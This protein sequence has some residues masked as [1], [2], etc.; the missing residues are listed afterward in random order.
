MIDPPIPFFL[1]EVGEDEIREVV[2]TLR[3]GWL[4][5]GPRTRQ[6][7]QDF[8]ELVGARHA[9]AVN[10]AT[11]ALHLALDA[12]GIQPGD[13]VL[14]PTMTFAA[15]AEVVIYLGAKPVLVDC[16]PRT[17]NIN[18]E[19]AARAVTART[20]AIM[21]VHYGGRPCEMGPILDLA[22]RHGL[23]V[24]EDAAHALPA[25]YGDRTIGSIGDATCFSFYANKTITTGE[26][27]MLTTDDADLADR[28][29]IMS[30]HGISKDAWRRFTAEG[31]WYYEILRPGYKYNMTDIAAALGLHQLRKAEEFREARQRCARWYDEALVEIDAVE[32]PPPAAADITHAWHLYPIQLRLERLSIDRG[33]FIR[34]MSAAGITTSVHWMPLHM[35]QYYRETYGY[36]LDDF[37]VAR[38]AF[39]RLISLPIYP[40]MA[41]E[42]VQRVAATV[43]RIAQENRGT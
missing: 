26:G 1:P 22:E 31:N 19:A 41:Q 42:Q 3:S 32:L 7:E 12:V 2:E 18:P 39:D 6:F 33:E 34:Q 35:H 21:P 10:S 36:Q 8:A 30:L 43:R 16:L 4:T 17:L 24:I 37:P 11:A 40:R 27:G 20:R 25:R 5:T 23:K 38:E 28:A 9:V 29:R 15:T 13:E 14:V